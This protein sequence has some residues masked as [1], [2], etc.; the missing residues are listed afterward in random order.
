MSR[1]YILDRFHLIGIFYFF[2][3]KIKLF[4]LISIFD[5]LTMLKFWIKK[6]NLTIEAKEVL[7]DKGFWFTKEHVDGAFG[8]LYHNILKYARFQEHLAC[9]DLAKHV[10]KHCL[11]FYHIDSPEH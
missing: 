6:L 7:L 8:H 5:F 4:N 3:M 2:I 9:L 10:N 11:Q 1:L